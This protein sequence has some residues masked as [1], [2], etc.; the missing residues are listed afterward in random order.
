MTV[1]NRQLS[2]L[3]I[4]AAALVAVTVALYGIDWSSSP[5]FEKG[6]LLIQGLDVGNVAKI[7]LARKD[8]AVTLA[9]ARD[10]F[11]VAERSNYPASVKKVNE[12]IIKILGI[13][14]GEKVTTDK[15]NHA[16]LGVTKDSEDALEVQLQGSDGKAIVA[17]VVGKNVPRASGSYVRLADQDTVYV[18]EESLYTA[19]E[20][21][22]YM[23]T[24]IVNVAKED[25]TEA[26]VQLKDAS[27]AI[28]R[29]KDDKIVLQS[30]PEGKQAKSTEVES[31]FGGLSYFTFEN[32]LPA[33]DAGVT[34][35]TTFTAQTKK[36]LGYTVQLGKKDNKDYIRITCQGP[37]E[38]LIQKSLRIS[39]TE[40]KKKLEEKDAVL[41]AAK[42]A[43]D[44]N[45]LH[46]AWV[47][48]VSDWKAK[49]LRKPLS[50]LV[51]D[52]PKPS[53][54]TEISASH[55]LISYKGAEKAD[56]K[57]TRTKDEAKK[58]AEEVLAKAKAEGADF[59]ALAK[60]YSDGPTKT[61]GGNLGPFKK[62]TMAKPFEEAAWK[63]DVGAISDVVE[64]PF[65]FHVIKRTK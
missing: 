28:A 24:E 55:V 41:T 45:A 46:G 47:Y 9:R 5:D 44:F 63:L 8:K 50:D 31:V 32:V 22:G 62:G 30:V 16:E 53:E 26:K 12:L 42:K 4:V 1:T 27:Y 23:E 56:A 64:T 61:K 36:H 25:V 33:K 2:T 14:C 65:G 39:T 38:E 52:I 15:A 58:R 43:E 40:E 48:E 59:A 7:V 18:S 57:I 34:F 21:T 3:A 35:D 20:P 19:S 13:R 51:E 54:P 29:D 10:G 6:A 17:V 49:Y 37:P 60:E 11:V